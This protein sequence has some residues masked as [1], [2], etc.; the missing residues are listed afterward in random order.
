MSA[1][2]K[3]TV[4]ALAEVRQASKIL[5]AHSPKFGEQENT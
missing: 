2:T 4:S 3:R 5:L 1:N